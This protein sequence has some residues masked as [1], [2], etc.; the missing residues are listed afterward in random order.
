MF[1]PCPLT[2]HRLFGVDFLGGDMLIH[3]WI[4]NTAAGLERWDPG[5]RL[6]EKGAERQGGLLE[7]RDQDRDPA[8]TKD[9]DQAQASSSA[10]M[11]LASQGVRHLEQCALGDRLLG[12]ASDT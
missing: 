8:T 5:P 4:R 9:A 6:G 1:P 10:L 2:Q 7:Q 3:L 12:H 11:P